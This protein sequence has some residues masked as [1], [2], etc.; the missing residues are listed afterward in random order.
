MLAIYMFE[1]QLME[2]PGQ[3]GIFIYR[4]YPKAFSVVQKLKDWAHI[5]VQKPQGARGGMVTG[6]CDTRITWPFTHFIQNLNQYATSK[7]KM[8]ICNLRCLKARLR[9]LC[10]KLS[11]AQ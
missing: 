2:R 8:L 6:Q 4:P 5:L 10:N 9:M 3:R 1:S 7:I 11:T